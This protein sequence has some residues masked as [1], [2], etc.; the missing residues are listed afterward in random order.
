MLCFVTVMCKFLFPYLSVM[1]LVASSGKSRLMRAGFRTETI[2]GV[3][4]P[5][6]IFTSS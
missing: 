4:L 5:K 3:E 6:K 1:P 2:I